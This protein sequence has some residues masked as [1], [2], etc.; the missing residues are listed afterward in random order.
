MLAGRLGVIA[1]L[2]AA[3]SGGSPTPSPVQTANN[4]AKTP[5]KPDADKKAEATAK[6]ESKAKSKAKVKSNDMGRTYDQELATLRRRFQA[7]L[8]RT[9][10]VAGYA[11]WAAAGAVALQ[12][13]RMTG[14]YTDYRTAEETIDKTF[15]FGKG[16][17]HFLRARFNYHLHRLDRIDADMP[18]SRGMAS[19]SGAKGVS[20]VDAF[21]GKLAMQRGQFD[22]A[23]KFWEAAEAKSEGAARM[24]M[25]LFAFK[26]ADFDA[27]EE[28]YAYMGR[29]Y[30]GREA[31]GAAW[32]D[33]VQAIIDLDRGRYDEALVHLDAADADMSG[34]WLV[35]E[36]RAEITALKGDLKTAEAMYREIVTRT[37]NPEFMDALASVLKDTDRDDEAQEWISRAT[38]RYEEQMTLYPEAAYGHALGHFLDFGPPQRALELARKNHTVRPNVEAKML[39]AQAEL[40]MN[41]VDAAKAMIDVAVATPWSTADL[42]YT[43]YEVYEATGDKDKAAA[44]LAKAKAINPHVAD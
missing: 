25:A 9:E 19:A 22:E 43:A 21:Q 29:N 17:A 7:Q 33:L 12:I 34:Y 2:V 37:D 20:A 30:H 5:G 36:H 23:V 8:K 11:A 6:P 40:A 13:A 14:K 24:P 38:A 42:H 27:A 39:L 32:L 3:C 41:N 44:Q 16:G 10:K 1:C 35:D 18:R 31:E 4:D 15:T 26:T 28:A